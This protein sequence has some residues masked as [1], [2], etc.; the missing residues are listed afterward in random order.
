M[1]PTTKSVSIEEF[2]KEF[3]GFDRRDSITKDVCVPAPIGCGM[4]IS[5]F[6]DELSKSE[7][8]IS[9][10]CQVCQDKIFTAEEE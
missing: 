5:G 7:F 10:L 1:K 2:I 3:A 9:G 6:K 4:P 8:R